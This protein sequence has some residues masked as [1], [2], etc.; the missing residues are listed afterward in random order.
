MMCECG[1]MLIEKHGKFC[2]NIFNCDHSYRIYLLGLIYTSPHDTQDC[3]ANISR[4]LSD[5]T[6]IKSIKKPSQEETLSDNFVQPS[7]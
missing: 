1:Q 7:L 5:V 6:R 4:L 3:Q 2:Q